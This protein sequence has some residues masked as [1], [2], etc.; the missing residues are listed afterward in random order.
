MK[1]SVMATFALATTL[2]FGSA[3]AADKGGIQIHKNVEAIGVVSGHNT[4]AADGKNAK[5]VNR[6]GAISG[7]VTVKGGAWTVGTVGKD[8][9]N[10]AKGQN[11]AACNEIGSMASGAECH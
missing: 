1:K 8:N 7:N 9:I 4:N 10:L 5:A 6:I 2:A 11:A 3:M